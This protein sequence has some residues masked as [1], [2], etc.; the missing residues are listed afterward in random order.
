M[1]KAKIVAIKPDGKIWAGAKEQFVKGI[2]N[3]I[4]YFNSVDNAIAHLKHY[5]RKQWRVSL[6]TRDGK[7]VRTI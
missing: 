2:D 4:K 5:N 3:N 7:F 1:Y 6:Y